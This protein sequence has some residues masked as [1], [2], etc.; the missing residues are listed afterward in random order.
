MI[1]LQLGHQT[2]SPHT[3]KDVGKLIK[4]SIKKEFTNNLSIAMAEN[5]IYTKEDIISDSSICR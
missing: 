4:K 2:R 1:W 5:C 3:Q